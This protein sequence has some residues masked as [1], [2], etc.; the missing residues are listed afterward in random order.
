M[1]EDPQEPH[2]N[3]RRAYRAGVHGCAIVHA[4][5][6]TALRGIIIDLGLGGVRLLELV[7]DEPGL[8]AGAEVTIELECAGAGWVAQRGRVIRHGDG[9]LA[10]RFHALSPEVEDL[11]EDE[12]LG[13]VEAQRAPRVVVVDRAA[14]RRHRVA[15]ALRDAGCSPLEA[16]TPLEAVD[17]VERSRNHVCAVALSENLTQTQADDLVRFLAEAHPEV[18]VALIADR[19]AGEPKPR[20][21]VAAVIA[22]EGDR[23]VSGPVRALVAR[24]RGGCPEGT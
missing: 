1:Q 14:Q 11:I 19:Q 13:D 22:V 21:P 10:I 5:G 8:V 20:W 12:V 3:R 2:G 6:D 15:E 16:A 24:L 23:P 18:Q 9:E 17:I 7:R 4:P